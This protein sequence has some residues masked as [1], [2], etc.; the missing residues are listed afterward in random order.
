[1]IKRPLLILLIAYILGCLLYQLTFLILVLLGIGILGLSLYYWIRHSRKPQ[2]YFVFLVPLLVLLGAILMWNQQLPGPVD[3]A[4]EKGP[5]YT[6]CQG[7]ITDILKKNDSYQLL[8]S[9]VFYDQSLLKQN[10]NHHY[11][12]NSRI[13]VYLKEIP[14]LAI[15]NTVLVSGNL[16]LFTTPTNPAQFNERFYNKLQ[17]MD[18]RMLALSIKVIKPTTAI[19]AQGFYDLRQRMKT[20]YDS[21]GENTAAVLNAMLLGDT[22]NLTP[23][24]KN[25]YQAAGISHVISISGMHITLLGMA[26]FNLVAK[27]FGRNWATLSSVL[28][29]LF[30]GILTG[31]SVSTNRAVV[32]M[33]IFL[34]AGIVG[35]TYDLLSAISLSALFILIQAPMQ[36]YNMGFLLSYGAILGIGICYPLFITFVPVDEWKKRGECRMLSIGTKGR[37][38]FYKTSIFLKCKIAQ[39]LTFQFAIQVVLLPLI[40][41][42]FYRVPTYSP[43]MNLLVVPMMDY[44]IIFGLPAGFLGL[45]SLSLGRFFLAS[46]YYIIECCNMICGLTYKLPGYYYVVGKPSLSKLLIYAGLVIL[47]L[48]LAHK[49]KKFGLLCVLAGM[50]FLLIRYPDKGNLTV[51]ALDVGQGDCFVLQTPENRVILI[52]GGSSDINQVGTYRILPYLYARGISKVDYVFVTHC[53]NDH[54]SGVLELL[55]ASKKGECQVGQ[56]IVPQAAYED[57]NYEAMLRTAKKCQV[58]V[59]RLSQGDYIKEGELRID[60]IH[61]TKSYVASS[62][63]DSSFVLSL[64]FLEFDMLFTGDLEA[65]G[66][67]VIR[68][69]EKLKQ[70]EVLKVAHHGSK[71]STTK[72]FLQKISP[73]IGLISCGRDNPYGH[74]NRELLERLKDIGCRYY[75]TRD[76]GAT[77]ITTDGSRVWVEEYKNEV[78]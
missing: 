4:L 8:L 48:F 6:S 15:G 25:L 16:S 50:I 74:P 3:Q 35:R 26:I 27:F 42:S 51:T 67:E 33:S 39:L 1:M 63:N 76:S 28:F 68:K 59:L 73:Q 7:I 18:Y 77:T 5:V 21:L 32:M 17:N 78:E 62:S 66:E 41:V 52:D 61:P 75:V 14:D 44:V 38:R 23:E 9:D 10:S 69:Q 58:P 11:H 30:Y 12:T 19:I 31:F 34:G 56:L 60:C 49:G 40:L 45:L 65:R 37:L 55:E 57:D 36:L 43:L 70:Y 71:N 29:I 13:Y 2:D 24:I 53:D 22:K 54:V 47:G 20:V 46:N 72:E 64:S